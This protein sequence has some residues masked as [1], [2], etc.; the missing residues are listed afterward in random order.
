MIWDTPDAQYHYEGKLMVDSITLKGAFFNPDFGYWSRPYADKIMD[1]KNRD[2]VYSGGGLRD[3][4]WFNRMIER[5][6]KE[7]IKGVQNIV[8]GGK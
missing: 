4:H 3:D 2:L 6:E 5:E 7:L 8:N 1:P